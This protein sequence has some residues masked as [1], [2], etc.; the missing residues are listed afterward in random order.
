MRSVSAETPRSARSR[1]VALLFVVAAAA[2]AAAPAAGRA[3][4]ARAAETISRD[5]LAAI[6][7]DLVFVREEGAR[8]VA[9]TMHADGSGEHVLV[10]EADAR[11]ST[12]PAAVAAGGRIVALVRAAD[13]GDAHDESIVVHDV[14]TG[15]MVQT[16]APGAALVRNPAL[17][18]DGAALVYE[19]DAASFR[20][21][22]AVDVKSSAAP[23]RLTDDGQ[24]DYEP[25]FF[26]DGRALAFTSSRDGEAEIY[27][28]ASD[29]SAPVRL[30]SSPGD[31]LAP[32]V[33]PDGRSIAFLSGRAGVD[34]VFVMNADGSGVRPVRPVA[35]GDIRQDTE[36][37]H[38]WSPDGR[39]LVFVA[40]GAAKDAK[41]RILAWDAA[42]DTTTV[43]TDGKSVDDMPSYSPDG[44]YIAFV[45][46]RDGR[47][48]VWIMRAD[49]SGR[50][51][52]ASSPATRWLPSWTARSRK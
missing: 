52:V 14:T 11:V 42:R 12:Y 3:K 32:K 43:L 23:R 31:D 45:S 19:S 1:R 44:R 27:R 24:G 16:I 30:T 21:L 18:P 5:E 50:T 22:F 46:D 37:E 10:E 29:G 28:S 8:R 35:M 49:G 4:R 13:H 6:D 41:A 38:A 25:S 40:R 48:D 20:D 9:S 36:R 7:A 17:S 26:P 47:P 34:R 2:L 39:S 51:R 15:R 33:A